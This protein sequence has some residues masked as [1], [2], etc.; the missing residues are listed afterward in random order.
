M[1]ED[2]WNNYLEFMVLKTLCH[3]KGSLEGMLFS[4]TPL[5]DDL[6]HCHILE[7]ILYED[8]MK[9]IKKVNPL[10]DRIHHSFGLSLTSDADKTQRRKSTAIAYRDLF[11]KACSWITDGPPS[12]PRPGT[13][14][15]G[16]ETRAGPRKAKL[17]ER[18]QG[19][20]ENS[21]SLAKRRGSDPFERFDIYIKMLT[22]KTISLN[23][24]PWNSI[25]MVKDLI[26][27]KE[28]I[29]PDQSRLIF[30][31][32][33]LADGRTLSDYNIQRG[34]TIHHILRLSGC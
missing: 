9:L 29:P 12:N 25:E 33:L 23:V 13:S 32:E 28:G 3:D 20:G 16:H 5:M 31:G 19:D 21:E 6:W 27:D 10:M 22:G 2:L 8:F 15:V 14:S 26:Q 24:R 30:A 11:G 1:G 4:T 34:S 7:T 18:S 17:D